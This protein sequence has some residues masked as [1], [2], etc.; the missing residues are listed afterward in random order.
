MSTQHTPSFN[1][2]NLTS[3]PIGTLAG[4]NKLAVCACIVMLAGAS[5]FAWRQPL[6][7]AQ[8]KATVAIDAAKS[9]DAQKARTAAYPQHK[10][11]GSLFTRAV[12]AP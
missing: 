1:T 2:A 12:G 11:L 10:Q 5:A 7:D 3:Q 9:R 6:S 8:T 4:F